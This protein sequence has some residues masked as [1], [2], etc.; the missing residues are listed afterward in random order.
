[1]KR[2]KIGDVVAHNYSTTE[3]GTVTE[4]REGEYSVYVKWD[5]S[6]ERNDWFKPEVLVHKRGGG[7]VMTM[8]DLNINAPK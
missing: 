1:M 7:T 2:F 8:G 6:P 3:V 4:V 5:S